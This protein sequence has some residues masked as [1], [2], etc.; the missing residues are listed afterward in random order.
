MNVDVQTPPR[1][2]L[3]IDKQ[4]NDWQRLAANANPDSLVLILD[5]ESAGLTQIS[6]Y[7]TQLS[8]TEG[9]T[10]LQ[11]IHILAHGSPGNLLLGA[12][13]VTASNL[14]QYQQQL[15]QL[16]NALT[17]KG[18]ILLY[19]CKVA[20]DS[21]GVQFVRQFA[22][23]TQADV[24]ASDDVTGTALLTGDWQL[25]IT[26]GEIESTLPL[27]AELVDSYA[28][29]LA[30]YTG[31]ADKDFLY[32]GAG[33][34]S[35]FGLAGNDFLNG[36]EG[37][38]RIDGGDGND[39][40]GGGEGNDQIEGGD[41]NDFITD[42]YGSNVI[43][44]GA[45]NDTITI[46]SE[47]L[48]NINIITGGTGSD[49]YD[50]RPGN[51]G[52]QIIT[53]FAVGA[54]GDKL[55]ISRV[56]SYISYYQSGN[57]FADPAFLRLLSEGNDT[58]LQETVYG[59]AGGANGWNTL[60]RLQNVAA[61][62]LTADNF[63]PIVSPDGKKGAGF[64]ITGTSGND[65]LQ[66]SLDNDTLYGLEGNDRLYGSFGDNILDGGEGNDH[67]RSDNGNDTLLGGAGDDVLVD[68]GGSNIV[69]G[70][71]GDDNITMN[72]DYTSSY[73]STINIL[74]G[75]TGKDTY[76]L[77]L[78]NVGQS[79]IITDFAA[80]AGGDVF[81]MSSLPYKSIGYSTGNPFGSLGYLILLIQGAD[82]LLQ[83][84]RDGV[85][86]NAYGPQTIARLQNVSATALSA[87]NFTQGF[88]F[89]SPGISP[90][91][92]FSPTLTDFFSAVAS[93]NED[94]PITVSFANLLTQGNETVDT[95][96]TVDS[97]VV[98]AVSSGNL[99]IGV[100]A[101]TATAW[102][103]DTNDVVDANHNAYWTPA[104]NANGTL[105]A[106]T[107]V[108]KDNSGLR[109]DIP[110]QV[111][112]N[113]APSNDAPTG[114]AT[115]QLIVGTEDT[116]YTFSAFD[117]LLGFSDKDGD[118]LAIAN[119][120]SNHGA[121]TN[122]NNGT[123]TLTPTANYS[124]T[125]SLR[126]NVIDG[127][128]GSVDAT[129][130]LTLAGVNDAPSLNT[131]ASVVASG[132]EDAEIA[133]TFA[134]LQ[135]QGN[136]AD[137][138]GMVT[139]FVV[140]AISSGTLKIGS[141][142]ATATE[143]NATLN[144][145]INSKQTGYWTPAANVN[146]SLA[147]VTVVAK[148]DGGLESATAIQTT[149]TV[150]AVNDAPI[151][152]ST[153]VAINYTD[154]AADDTFLTV[155]GTLTGTD[156]DA[157][158]LAYGITGGTD[159]GDGTQSMSNPYGELTV[160]KATGAYRFVANDAA[161]EGLAVAASSQFT[162]TVSDGLLS[163]S[164]PLVINIAQEG[165]T[166]TKD[167]D[168]LPGTPGNDRFDGLSGADTM[169]GGLGDDTYTIDNSGDKIVEK[170]NEGTDT[171]L[172]V[173]NTTLANHVENLILIGTTALNGT[174]NALNN[175][176]TGNAAANVLDGG[177]G[178]DELI[179][180]LGDDSYW[181]DN[182]GDKAIENN[183]AGIDTVLSLMSYTLGMNIENLSLIG[184]AALKGIGNGLNNSLIGNKGA[185]TL[186]GGAGDDVLD[187]G[188][189]KDV[190]TG[191]VGHDIFRFTNLSKDTITDFSVT[192]DTIQLENSVFTKLIA[193]GELSADNFRVG[194]AAADANDF[195]IYNS[196]TGALIYDSNG[197]SAGGATQ[198][199]VLGIGLALTHSDFMVS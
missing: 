117:L 187:G 86:G 83:W 89:G 176:L 107:A 146:G 167:N 178:A 40:L 64:D 69:D 7:L 44:A 76:Y 10:P 9:Y 70:G 34:D 188:L 139:A 181:L 118:N 27:T 142:P 81:D 182:V 124:G 85:A 148:D 36:G 130:N 179:G 109:S 138:D 143:W 161:I 137:I 95:T 169:T 62:T 193:T 3:V 97:F 195:V 198:I 141:S 71:T 21:A 100:S 128:G 140:K 22:E 48:T 56:L 150:A 190:L 77:D 172:S 20:A 106:F 135:S 58:L 49:T 54:G 166:E 13:T 25:E 74:T 67:L 133:V 23:L 46:G 155:L 88:P 170:L 116:A 191:G 39:D 53:D 196:N 75:G 156:L 26:T 158:T 61:S 87:D 121:I 78:Y 164:K 160:T 1:Q 55:D 147:A 103:A 180:G 171:V 101:E 168:K 5:L 145:T 42:G 175:S 66:G 79:T 24:A 136:E 197:N 92:T 84:D 112:I 51:N 65:I 113:I 41:G 16:G 80:G 129:L 50:L 110:T 126:Y 32:V 90:V 105:N 162:V 99:S 186:D 18:D 60:V 177:K 115:A 185:N 73:T 57:P 132:V 29:T 159:N 28:D 111:T 37:D 152:T 47:S 163:D 108:V 59:T 134:S 93:G 199:A 19:G 82:T 114:A 12:S 38:D 2:L 183:D 127:N 157:T 98:K 104:A 68:F 52:Q 63:T 194:T 119:L 30:V 8:A 14:N 189:G 144:N 11:S 31:T 122:H 123:F 102:A 173:I 17:D 165:V 96:R 33:N 91:A 153:P 151:M 131:F 125:V 45:G 35:V 192:D 15:A 154:T 149:V 4:V 6:D 43:D 94:N 72:T 184:S 120:V 174:G